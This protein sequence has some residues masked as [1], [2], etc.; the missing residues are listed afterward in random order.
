[1]A[2][3]GRWREAES[4]NVLVQQGCLV[5]RAVPSAASSAAE[6][7]LSRA[8]RR[9][10]GAPASA[11]IPGAFA[12][13][14][15][16]ATSRSRTS[17]RCAA[18]AASSR[19]ARRSTCRAPA[20]CRCRSTCRRGS[21]K[22]IVW[23]TM[24]AAAVNTREVDM[25]ERHQRQPLYQRHRND[26]RFLLGHACRAGDRGRASAHQSSRSARRPS[27]ASTACARP[28]SRSARQDHHLRR[29]LRAA[30]AGLA[31]AS[32]RRRLD[33]ARH[34]LDATPSSRRW[35]ATPPIRA[36]GGGLQ[37]FDYFMLQMLNREINVLKHLRH[38]KYTHPVELY[39]ELLRISGEL[40]TFSPKRL[41]PEYA[42]YDHDSPGSRCSSRCCADIQRL[43]EPRH[44]PARSASI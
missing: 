30:G 33:R 41:A 36:P 22:Q 4:P 23:M 12:R 1:M 35:R 28:H 39:Q 18:P 26:H 5:R 20:R 42:D 34:R 38:S 27:P 37:T 14:R 9:K 31:R 10:P 32:G 24:P 8:S 7:P 3:H 19:T 11:P 16:T 15:S 17:S 25:A 40:W 2:S 6:R 43:L 13:S 29:N 21:D 44:R